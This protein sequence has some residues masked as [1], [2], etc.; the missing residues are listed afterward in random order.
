[1]TVQLVFH[2]CDPLGEIRFHLAHVIGQLGLIEASVPP[3]PEKTGADRR[4]GDRGQM[5]LLIEFAAGVGQEANLVR[6][7]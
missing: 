6:E 5:G 1:M 2:T 4:V 7:P 3:V